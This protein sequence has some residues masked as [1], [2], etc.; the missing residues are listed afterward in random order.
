LDGATVV[1]TGAGSGLG[2]RMATGA[3]RKGAEVHLWDL[4]GG[5]A[6]AVRDEILAQGGRARSQA[7]D[8]TDR[9]A[10]DAAALA[11]GPVD[12]VVNNAGVVSGRPLLEDTPE[13]IDR[14]IDVNLK[15][16]FW[17]T[18][19]FLPGMV[20]RGMGFVVTMASAAGMLAGSRMAA[21]AA[22]KA[23]AIA[24]NESLR[25]EM[26]ELQTGV[27]TMVVCPFYIDT[28]MFAGVKTKVPAL[29][30]IL[31]PRRVAGAVLRGIERGSKQIIAP[32]FVRIVP[33]LR[34]QPVGMADWTADLFGINSSMEDFSGREGDRV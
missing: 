30:P 22:S 6:E 2:R 24:F 4:D 11:A 27:G 17:V 12:V 16:L 15:A 1:I 19:A 34:L 14:T 29:L 18:R 28:G 3:A 7:V 9:L 13:G 8:V 10:V 32:P 5:R 20:E 31:E 33:A 21:Y 25:N 26:R 23:G